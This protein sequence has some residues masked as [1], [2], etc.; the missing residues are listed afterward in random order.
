MLSTRFAATQ[1]E[2]MMNAAVNVNDDG[3]AA[4]TGQ[5]A[6]KVALITGA[7]SGIGLA[8]AILLARR[9][10]KVVAAAR[11]QEEL[12]EKLAAIRSAG[13]VAFPG[14]EDSSYVSGHALLADAGY[15]VA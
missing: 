2:S 9:G 7:S 8:T 6:G 10:A 12:D 15:S 1:L 11:R 14:S 4:S 13:I 3:G 5:L